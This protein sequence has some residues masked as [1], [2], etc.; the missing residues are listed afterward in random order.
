MC[1]KVI[2]E[3][4]KKE[5]DEFGRNPNCDIVNALCEERIALANQRW[6]TWFALNDYLNY[7]LP[8]APLKAYNGLLD[9]RTQ[10]GVM[11]YLRDDPWCP[12]DNELFAPFWSAARKTPFY[13]EYLAYMIDRRSR[14]KKK[15]KQSL[16]DRVLPADQ[17]MRAHIVRWFPKN[18]K[19]YKT[20]R[21][22]LQTLHIMKKDDVGND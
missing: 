20:M 22:T 1:K 11:S 21:K 9:A 7:Q 15:I 5:M 14:K 4:Y 17:P 12:K 18:S 10:P 6:S 19:R 3:K 13:E 2:T 8:Y 16:M